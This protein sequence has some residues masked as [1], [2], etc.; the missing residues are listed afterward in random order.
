[1]ISLIR[2]FDSNGRPIFGPLPVVVAVLCDPDNICAEF[3]YLVLRLREFG[4]E[5]GNQA[6][7][8]V[9]LIGESARP[10]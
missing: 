10:F 6:N 4:F 3:D 7:E 8:S 2:H 5:G 1:L 9:T